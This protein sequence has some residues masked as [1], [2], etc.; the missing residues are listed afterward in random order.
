MSSG[1]ASAYGTASFT[2]L[3]VGGPPTTPLAPAPPADP[4]PTGWTCADVG[5][6]SPVGD[7]TG[8]G[9]SLTL[10]GTGTGFPRLV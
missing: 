10:A 1:S 7:T 5:N 6:P 8:S 2:A 3:S 4:C 9:S